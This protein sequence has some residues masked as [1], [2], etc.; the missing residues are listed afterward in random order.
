[1]PLHRLSMYH[2]SRQLDDPFPLYGNSHTLTKRKKNEETKK[3]SQS[4]KDLLN[5]D[6]TSPCL[7]SSDFPSTPSVTVDD[8]MVL[9]CLKGFPNCTSPGASKLRAQ[10]LLDVVS[11]STAP[12]AGKCLCSLTCFMIHFFSGKGPAC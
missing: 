6:P 10:H 3:L 9:S 2:I 4:L 8:S 12:A 11:N 5:R 1:M 7:D